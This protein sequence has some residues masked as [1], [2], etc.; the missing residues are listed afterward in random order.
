MTRPALLAPPT[1]DE[2]HDV[3]AWMAR[4]RHVD[5]TALAERWRDTM[6]GTTKYPLRRLDLFAYR[7][8][9]YTEGDPRQQFVA[10]AARFGITPQEALR[11]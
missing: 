8:L 1:D 7:D 10:Y 2:V 9:P 4:V 11:L 3:F 6:N 5:R